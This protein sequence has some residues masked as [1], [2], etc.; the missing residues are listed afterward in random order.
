MQIIACPMI[1]YWLILSFPLVGKGVANLLIS[2]P[3][4][5]L[6]ICEPYLL[7]EGIKFVHSINVNSFT[8]KLTY[9]HTRFPDRDFL[10]YVLITCFHESWIFLFVFFFSRKKLVFSTKITVIMA[11]YNLFW[12]LN[13]NPLRTDQSKRQNSRKQFRFRRFRIRE[14]MWWTHYRSATSLCPNIKELVIE[15]QGRDCAE[16]LTRMKVSRKH[17]IYIRTVSF[18]YIMVHLVP[19]RFVWA[20]YQVYC[21]CC[22]SQTAHK[23]VLT[24]L[25]K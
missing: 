3:R 4:L 2:L 11:F 14:N 8:Y 6:L 19:S 17:S 23:L 25:A 16:A 1:H 15:D 13:E 12:F 9:L 7:R 10:M 22:S 18:S 20:R 5:T 24:G 21:V